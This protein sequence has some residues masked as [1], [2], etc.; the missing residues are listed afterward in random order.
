M[1]KTKQQFWIPTLSSLK[2]VC[3]L[4]RNAERVLCSQVSRGLAQGTHRNQRCNWG[5]GGLGPARCRSGSPALRTGC[6]RQWCNPSPSQ[7]H[8]WTK[9]WSPSR[10]G[11]AVHRFGAFPVLVVLPPTHNEAKIMEKD[12]W[13]MS[14]TKHHPPPSHAENNHF[15]RRIN[16]TWK[17]TTNNEI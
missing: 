4:N 8:E 1:N 17:V 15:C 12:C 11:A 9:A 13:Q 10:S 6:S 14:L 3:F 2:C 16:T 5:P 7:E